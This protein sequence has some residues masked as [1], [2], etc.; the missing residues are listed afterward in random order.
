[1]P[2]ISYARPQQRGKASLPAYLVAQALGGDDGDLVTYSL[3]RLEV[4]GE[5]RIVSLN[6]DLCGLL[7]GFRSN[8]THFGDAL[9]VAVVVKVGG[10]LSRCDTNLVVWGEMADLPYIGGLRKA[11]GFRYVVENLRLNNASYDNL[12]RALMRTRTELLQLP[13][14]AIDRTERGTRLASPCPGQDMMRW[15][16][17]TTR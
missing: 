8:S 16:T 5:L 6:D 13:S 15:S 2:R 12:S 11:H 14:P 17:W 3:V 9:P 1:V 4:E 7:D 10:T